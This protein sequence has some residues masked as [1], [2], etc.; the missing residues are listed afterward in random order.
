[1][2]RPGKE[3]NM[4]T[5]SFD[6]KNLHTLIA[7][8]SGSG[9]STLVRMMLQSIKTAGGAQLILIDPKRTELTEQKYWTNCLQYAAK[10]DEIA[11]ALDIAAMMLEDRLDEMARKDIRVYDGDHVFVVVDEMAYLMQGPQRKQYT[12]VLYDLAMLGRAARMHLILCTQVATQDV[13][14]ACIRDNMANIVCLRQRDAGKYRYLL[15]CFPG[16]LPQFGKCYLFTPEM[17]DR[18]EKVETTQVWNRIAG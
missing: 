7:G 11:D 6:G 15:G 14:P 9:K 12:Q 10:P 5:N 4:N 1:M 18:P 3:K 8:I 2:D 13:I 16:R 17:F